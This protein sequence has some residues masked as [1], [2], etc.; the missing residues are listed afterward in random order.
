MHACMS[1]MGSA[2]DTRAARAQKIPREVCM[3]D[4]HGD[5]MK[6]DDGEF[7]V[8]AMHEARGGDSACGHVDGVAHGL[9]GRVAL[10]AVCE[11]QSLIPAYKWTVAFFSFVQL[12]FSLSYSACWN[13]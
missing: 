2:R 7:E 1:C 12:H 13:V 5:E 4:R 9:T 10:G 3:P 8:V 6:G 11:V